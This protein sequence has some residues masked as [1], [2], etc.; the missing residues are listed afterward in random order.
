[1]KLDLCGCSFKEEAV[2]DAFNISMQEIET[3]GEGRIEELV[4]ERVALVDTYR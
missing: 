1:M 2:K 4:I 3:V